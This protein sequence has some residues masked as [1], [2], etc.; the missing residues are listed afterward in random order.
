MNRSNHH[1]EQINF[2][3]HWAFC[4]AFLSI[5]LRLFS[6][7]SASVF[8]EVTK[9]TMYSGSI[10]FKWSVW[11]HICLIGTHTPISAT[12]CY[13]MSHIRTRWYKATAHTGSV[14]WE[15][16]KGTVGMAPLCSIVSRSL[17]WYDFY[18]YRQPKSLGLEDPIPRWIIHPMNSTVAN[19]PKY[20]LSWTAKLNANMISLA[21]CL[22]LSLAQC[23]WTPSASVSS[24]QSESC[25]LRSHLPSHQLCHSSWSYHM[26]SWGP[27]EGD[28]DSIFQWKA[29]QRIYGNVFKP[30]HPIILNI[31]MKI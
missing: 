2:K 16:R 25:S 11:L 1:Y 12:Y 29:C 19:M 28:R 9:W 31:F 24:E 4:T 26:L 18:G 3:T 5:D 13:V 21:L 8:D 20:G 22:R 23:L 7:H 10:H 6:R 15:F 30:P 14:G 27:R 17:N